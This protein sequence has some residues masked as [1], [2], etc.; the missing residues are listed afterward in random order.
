MH[1]LSLSPSGRSSHHLRSFAKRISSARRDEG[2]S[3][4]REG[5]PR[6]PPVCPPPEALLAP[7]GFPRSAPDRCYLGGPVPLPVHYLS[8]LEIWSFPFLRPKGPSELSREAL[9]TNQRSP[10]GKPV[11][12]STVPTNRIRAS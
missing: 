2:W 4:G 10:S 1:L 9:Q 7:P 11:Y 12:A 3:A 5:S 8:P 6:S